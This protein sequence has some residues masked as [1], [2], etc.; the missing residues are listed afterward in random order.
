MHTTP[1]PDP[2]NRAQLRRFG[3]LF[4]AM[5][6]LVFV[7]LLPWIWG[8]GMPTWPWF[9][10]VPIALLALVFPDGLRP[11]YVTWLRVAEII[12]RFNTVVILGVVF[13]FIFIPFGLVL[14]LF[15][16]PMRRKPDAAAAS[17][18]VAART[19]K[20]ENLERPF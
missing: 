6:L 17:Y 19:P 10:A 12:G 4:P 14:R 9:A 11:L 13:V 2:V 16:D 8:F 1:A 15:A 18:R 3:L 5:L 7:V 20:P